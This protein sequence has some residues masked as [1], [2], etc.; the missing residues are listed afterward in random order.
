[1]NNLLEFKLRYINNPYI[2]KN[3]YF[4]FDELN[5]L[6]KSLTSND[7]KNAGIS[8][9]LADKQLNKERENIKQHILEAESLVENGKEPYDK[10]FY[11]DGLKNFYNPKYDEICKY[12]NIPPLSNNHNYLLEKY[13]QE[14]VQKT[15]K[16]TIHFLG[17]KKSSQIM[18][19]LAFYWLKQA[20]KAIN[21]K[22]N[23]PQERFN[24][25][26]FLSCE[27]ILKAQK[28]KFSEKQDL[29]VGTGKKLIET[30]E[31]RALTNRSKKALEVRHQRTNEL[32]EQ[33]INE[34]KT[35]SEHYKKL[36]KVLSKNG[37]AQKF[38]LA[39]E[40]KYDTVRHRWLQGI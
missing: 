39:H 26:F 22:R 35:Q 36:G 28:F 17:V 12:F 31:K 19:L 3:T 14:N 4:I 16:I 27:A 29:I 32:K 10:F 21:S 33:A 7:L 25:Y 15:K 1:M 9:M 18:G 8:K 34:Y 30:S 40:L 6:L 24:N 11:P 2:S 5:I 37:F 38:A 13:L 20:T 23:N